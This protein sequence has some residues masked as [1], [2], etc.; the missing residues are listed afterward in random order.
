[1]INPKTMTA[2]FLISRNWPIQQLESGKAVQIITQAL[3]GLNQE[4]MGIVKEYKT[5]GSILH[6]GGIEL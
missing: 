5:K 1:M 6:L 3:K 2:C 4:E